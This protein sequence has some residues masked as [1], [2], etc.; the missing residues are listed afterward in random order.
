MINGHHLYVRAAIDGEV[1]RLAAAQ[2][3]TRNQ[4][5]FRCSAALASLGVNE[6]AILHHLK[7]VA[8][9]IGLRGKE[10]YT[11][12]KSGVRAGLSNPRDIPHRSDATVTAPTFNSSHRSLPKRSSADRGGK[13]PAFVTCGDEGPGTFPDEIRRHVYCRGGRPVRV[14]IKRGC[15]GYVNWYRVADNGVDGWQSAKPE[16]YVPCPYIGTIDPFD[17]EMS[18]DCLYWPEGEKDCD[19]LGKALLP[20]F[21]FGGTGD[22][23]PVC[24]IDY[25][26]GRH[27]VILAD[28]DAGGREHAVKKAALA[29]PVAASVKIIEFPEL[30]PKGDVSD[31]LQAASTA[32]L[33]SRVDATACWHP[34]RNDEAGGW[35]SAVITASELKTKAFSPVRYVVPGYIPEGVTIFAGKPKVGKSWLLYDVCL[36]AAADRFVLGTVKPSQGDVLYLALEDSQRRLKRRLE[37]LWPS[38]DWPS[39]LT[40]ATEWK[41]ADAGGLDDIAAWC[42]SVSDPVL[43]VVDTLEKFR[44]L[45]KTNAAAYST[46]YLAIAGLHKFAH[47]RGIAIVVIHHVRKMEADDPFDMVSGTNGLTGAADTL[48]VLKRHAGNVTLHARGRD[49]E[50]KETACQFDKRTCRWTLLGD[51]GEVFSSGERATIISVLRT[52]GPEGMTI[53]ELM[54]ATERNDRN[55]LDQLLFKMIRDGDLVKVKRGVYATAAGKIGKKERNDLQGTD[56]IEEPGNLTD[57]TDLTGQDLGFG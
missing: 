56:E 43:I 51:A 34:Q 50:E 4:T 54:A 14:K 23:L 27:V 3:G 39:R 1:A 48:L 11:T 8:E 41:R 35:R 49:I 55:A 10:L 30:D 7:P 31:F 5:L 15:G 6:G 45:A 21:T 47:S 26:R 12:V 18:G 32:E 37:K 29:Y 19:T 36:A 16:G 24:A 22:G 17:T 46:D 42:D 57:L 44:P 9:T 33:E 20:A 13:Q 28:N 38:G 25:V 40:L 2:P 53:A 52:A